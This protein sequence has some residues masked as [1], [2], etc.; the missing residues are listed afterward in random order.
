M[1]FSSVGPNLVPLRGTRPWR[2]YVSET[3]NGKPESGATAIP[4]RT[5]SFLSRADALRWIRQTEQ[6]LDRSALAYDPSSLERITVADLLRRY[7]RDVTPGKR[8][9]A[10]EAK[11][12]EIFLRHSWAEL[13]LARIT[14]QV[15]TLHRDRG[16]ARSKPER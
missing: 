10:S 13:T 4:P 11:R 6:E 1:F 7:V 5:K 15:F 2:P 16:Y 8:G 12:I 9:H 14:P 3:T